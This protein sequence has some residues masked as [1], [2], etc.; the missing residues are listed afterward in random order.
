MNRSKLNEA[1]SAYLDFVRAA[2]AMIVLF[3][4]ASMIFLTGG[5][6]NRTNVQSG[7]V[8]V[9]F[10]LS[11][12]LISYSTFKKHQ[13]EDYGFRE[14]FIDRF[15]RIY[16]A[17]LPALVFVWLAD[18][19]AMKY[20]PSP[21]P[22]DF[23]EIRRWI[24]RVPQYDTVQSWFGSLFMLQD[25]PLFQV[26]R[27]L[28]VPD[29]AWFFNKYG[30]A[31]PFWTISIEWWLY[32]T[33]GAVV[34]VHLRNRRE[35]TLK[36]IAVLACV[37]IVPFYFLVGGVD[38]CLTL[39]WITGMGVSLIFI[40]MPKW[41]EFLRWP[42]ADGRW[43]RRCAILSGFGVLCM[44]CRLVA[45]K[46]EGHPGEFVELQFSV[47]LAVAIFS[48]LFAL[49]SVQRVPRMIVKGT[50]FFA[51]YSYSL[52]LTH[53]TVIIYIYLR[54]PGHQHDPRF[55]WYSIAAS[56]VLAIAFWW[57]FERHY[58]KVA[59]LLKQIAR[60]QNGSRAAIRQN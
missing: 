41:A 57:V 55:F 5:F 12:F 34:L 27:R 43:A 16:C 17:Y 32:M 14:Y 2:A 49:A 1:Q 20:L 23:T 47:F 24:D 3:G 21:T 46:L 6:L 26:A 56:N 7:G 28:G 30:S 35:W 22:E 25:F 9:F 38:N 37:A 19:Q 42:F 36:Q 4:H 8:L 33:F 50:K 29:N 60:R 54:F 45:L 48:M 59:A 58:Q 31:S 40:N 53:A 13:D 51:G 52:Y 44:A 11:G 18:M 15:T 10:L 39:L